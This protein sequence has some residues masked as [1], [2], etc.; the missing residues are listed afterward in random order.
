MQFYHNLSWNQ[1]ALIELRNSIADGNLRLGRQ[2]AVETG[3]DVT[4]LHVFFSYYNGGFLRF[5]TA[6]AM[7]EYQFQV[8][9]YEVLRY[10]LANLAVRPASKW[11]AANVTGK[12]YYCVLIDPTQESPSS[13]LSK[14]TTEGVTI[15]KE[16]ILRSENR[17]WLDNTMNGDGLTEDLISA[18]YKFFKNTDE[19]IYK[20]IFFNF[21]DCLKF[22]EEKTTE[23]LAK[24]VE[25]DKATIA[26]YRE[27][28]T[29]C[30]KIMDFLS[31]HCGETYTPREKTPDEVWATLTDEQKKNL[32]NPPKAEP[33]PK[34]VRK[35]SQ[36]R[37]KGE[38]A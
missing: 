1:K 19:S 38:T 15:T 14:F 7:P 23:M 11:N 34:A 26:K 6:A 30:D 31:S 4:K 17:V 32:L 20:A 37:T 28:R 18:G 12:Y 25:T 13:S 36:K 35:A 29:E 33:T 8:Q 3:D 24:I 22:V 21:E 27:K 5:G 10:E 16:H 9:A 2:L